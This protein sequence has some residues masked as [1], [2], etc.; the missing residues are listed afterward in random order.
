MKY[1]SQHGLVFASKQRSINIHTAI[2]HGE[3]RR[4]LLKSHWQINV[5]VSFAHHMHTEQGMV[6]KVKI[7]ISKHRRLSAET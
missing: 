2:A 7:A 3:W 5:L 1:P 4:K 6:H